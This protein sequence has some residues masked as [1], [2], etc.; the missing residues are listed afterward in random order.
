MRVSGIVA[1][2]EN[3][4]IGDKGGLPWHLPNDLKHFK[5]ITTGHWIVMG[6]K[7][8]ESIGRPLPNRFNMVVS[9]TRTGIGLQ[10]ALPVT[11]PEEAVNAAFYNNKREL[12]VIGEAVSFRS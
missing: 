10:K 3:G 5:D 12:F 11:S 6:R 2:S 1:V 8:F 7:T 4:I 9:R